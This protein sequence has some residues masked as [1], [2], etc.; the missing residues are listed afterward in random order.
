MEKKKEPRA[1]GA[2]PLALEQLPPGD[3]VPMEGAPRVHPERQIEKLMDSIRNFGVVLP[4][5]IDAGGGIIAGHAV[6]EA[7]VRLGVEL[8]PCVRADHLT[9][10]QRR[11]YALADNRLAEDASWDPVRLKAEMLRLR[12]GH[13]LQ[14]ADT[15]FEPRELLRLRLDVADAPGPEDAAPEP[16]EGAV[17][18]PGDLWL[19]G[20]H[21]II[22][23]SST[24]ADTVA[25]LLDGERP[26]LM[27]TDPP[28]GVEYDPAWRNRL[29]GGASKRT[30]KVLNDD[31]ADWREAWAL[32]EGD[33][34][35]VWHAALHGGTVAES[36]AACG[37]DVRSQIVWGKPHFTLSRG[38]YHWQHECCWYAVREKG[39]SHWQ[40][41]RSESTLWT[42]GFQED[43]QTAHGTQKP[44]ECMRRPMLNNSEP[45]DL[46]YEPFSGSG[47]S[48]IAAETC[49]RR[50][51]AVELDPAYVDMAVRRFQDHAH[52]RAT[53]AG[54]GQT[55]DEVAKERAG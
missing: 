11:A 25:A 54:T 37:L 33:V 50:C 12:D 23:G 46:V 21:R 16:A 15:G 31:K 52:V 45:G 22:C 20:E 14:L 26:H 53:L 24:D 55:F 28:Y 18:R 32:F 44:V 41:S 47:T 4:V 51:R 39:K 43:A 48:I 2:R 35:Y 30:G 3:L 13:G 1:S 40:G 19:L 36:L 9:E 10:A 34:A 27:V 8:V 6:V 29:R 42:V 49:A 17:T 7:A 38:D 5:L